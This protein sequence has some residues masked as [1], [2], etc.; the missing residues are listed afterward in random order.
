MS[1]AAVSGSTSTA[2][3]QQLQKPAQSGATQQTARP[4]HHHDGA[5]SATATPSAGTAPSTAGAT[6]GVDT[7]A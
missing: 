2:L 6:S 5:E 4:H 3:A 7:V 1:V